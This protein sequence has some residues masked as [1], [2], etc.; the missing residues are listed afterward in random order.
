MVAACGKSRKQESVKEHG[1]G[2]EA[3]PAPPPPE[4]G[5]VAVAEGGAPAS[6]PPTA[7][8]FLTLADS[9]SALDTADPRRS[10]SLVT[11]RWLG[12]LVYAKLLR[13]ESVADDQVAPDLAAALPESP[14]PLTQIYSLR[15]GLA[16][17]QRPPTA[18]RP[19]VAEDVR[20]TI[21]SQ[22]DRDDL[23]FPR[24]DR[25]RDLTVE[26]PDAT[27]IV[28]RSA[29]VDA[30]LPA[31]LAGRWLAVL[32]R[33]LLDVDV[34]PAAPSLVRGCGPFTLEDGA[35]DIWQF[36]ANASY[37][38]GQPSL[39]GVAL[40]NLGAAGQAAAFAQG[41][42]D[43]VERAPVDLA[44]S[45]AGPDD[46]VTVTGFPA[47]VHLFLRHDR[48]PWDDLR[49]RRAVHLALDRAALVD[50]WFGEGAGVSGFIPP[51]HRAWA[52]PDSDLHALPGYRNLP[53]DR[54]EAHALWEVAGGSAAVEPLR[55]T[56]RAADEAGFAPG[57]TIAAQLQ[58]ALGVAVSV[59]PLEEAAL[60]DVV[61]DGSVLWLADFAPTS[62]EVLDYVEPLFHSRGALNTFGFVDAEV[63]AAIAAIVGTWDR[64]S[65]AV[66]VTALQQLLLDRLP[67]LPIGYPALATV[68]RPG[69][70]GRR[71]D[72]L[73]NAW[74]Y[75]AVRRD[76]AVTP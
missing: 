51:P 8:S 74:Q 12:Q 1:V 21:V 62:P 39:D 48:P 13:W 65:R 2:E 24:R 73:D 43:V 20:L 23:T 32:P 18:G 44:R 28:A 3:E 35:A 59:Q 54:G 53:G 5:A 72:I 40:R 50:A 31:L 52:L 42:I 64:S 25:L 70:V 46:R 68:A 11:E 47:V 67:T 69:I 55:L 56:V 16:W 17:D 63:D 26:A 60:L 19:L 14:E 30:R 57:A 41:T 33:E 45:L 37:Y 34:D 4:E 66:Q 7:P 38:G 6:P 49:R 61:I 10:L 29:A 36:R 22:Q 27:T 58:T 75:A 76:P 15:P 9:L 71:P